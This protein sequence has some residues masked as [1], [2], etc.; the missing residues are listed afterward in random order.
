MASRSKDVL[1]LLLFKLDKLC[2]CCY[3]LV[4]Q[5][6][7][8]LLLPHGLWPSRLLCPWGSPGKNIGVGLLYPSSGDLP[9]LGIEPT[10]PVLQ[11]DSLLL[12]HQGS[13]MLKLLS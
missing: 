2:M 6:C 12:S 7:P 1:I 5:L 4:A 9:N 10:S 8:T 11:A 3:C 13:P